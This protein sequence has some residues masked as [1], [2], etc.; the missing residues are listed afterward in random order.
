MNVIAGQ[1][2]FQKMSLFVGAREDHSMHPMS[3]RAV[4]GG[5]TAVLLVAAENVV[6][7]H[8]SGPEREQHQLDSVP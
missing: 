3:T 1:A 6:H 2:Y 7:R 8:H 5:T 4:T